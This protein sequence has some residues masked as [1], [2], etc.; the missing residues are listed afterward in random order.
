MNVGLVRADRLTKLALN[1]RAP[2]DEADE[3]IGMA[4]IEALGALH[5]ADLEARLAPLRAKDARLPLRRA[6]ERALADAGT[7]R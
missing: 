5:P 2:V 3:R 4:A 1:A 7:C 6:A